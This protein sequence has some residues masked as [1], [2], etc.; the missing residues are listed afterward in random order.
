MIQSLW[1]TV[2]LFLI[3]L[4]IYLPYDPAIS[5]LGIYTREMKRAS[6]K[7][8]EKLPQKDLYKSVNS[9]FTHNNKKLETMQIFLY[10]RIEKQT[11]AHP[12]NRI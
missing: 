11:V 8:N 2:W 9:S 6:T 12:H 7:R 1:K 10:R 5:I 4:S 3:K